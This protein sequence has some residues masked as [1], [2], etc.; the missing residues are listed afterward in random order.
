MVID[1]DM[2]RKALYQAVLSGADFEPIYVWTRREL[3]KQRDMPVDGYL[4][5]VFLQRGDWRGATAADLLEEVVQLAPRPAPVFFISQRWDDPHV[6]SVLKQAGKSSAKVIQ[7]LAWS[8]FEQ[9]VQPDAAAAS[10][11]SALRTKLLSELMLWHGRSSFRPE[12]DETIRI[13]LLADPQFGDEHTSQNALFTENWIAKKLRLDAQ[14]GTPVPDLIVIAG[15][16]THS[17]RPDQF[18]LA[19]ERLTHDLM[20]P[21]WGEDSI[22][23]RRDRIVVVPGNHDVNLRFSAADGRIFSPKEKEF[24]PDSPIMKSDDHAPYL[25]HQ[26]YALEPFRRFAHRITRQREW[27]DRSS[28]SWV[29]RRF[30]HCGIRFFVLNTVEDLDAN[31]PT[32]ACFNERTMRLINRSLADDNPDSIFSIAVSHHGLR[33]EG[34]MQET[35][36]ENWVGVGRHFFSQHKIRLWLYGHYHAFHRRNI[37][38]SPFED[39]P[40][41]MVQAPTTRIYPSTRGFCVIELKRK[42]GHVIDAYVHNYVLDENGTTTR[43]PALRIY[44]GGDAPSLR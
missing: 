37:T 32:Q 5:D 31:R 4:L 12:P 16:V 29:D 42:A 8:E 6:L 43:R 30:I 15:D 9:A 7:Y 24:R 17:G 23:L 34:S 11:L 10:R 21:L 38:G 22:E 44:G 27:Q 28:M 39:T 26:P 40:L 25:S 14:N 1:D 19:E 18:G 41:W 3:Q 33:P 35:E 36:V 2:D 13:L 20:A